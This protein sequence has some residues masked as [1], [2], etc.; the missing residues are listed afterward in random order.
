MGLI[1]DLVANSPNV[2]LDVLTFA[3][4]S[5]DPTTWNKPLDP[6]YISVL[7]P[8][9]AVEAQLPGGICFRIRATWPAWSGP[10]NVVAIGVT[11]TGKCLA[12]A[13]CDPAFSQPPGL[14]L[15]IQVFGQV[16]PVQPT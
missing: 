4:N 5:N 6:G 7:A 3:P 2:M 1:A 9:L 10:V 14:P 11:Y 15:S 16:L 12:V 8:C 13:L